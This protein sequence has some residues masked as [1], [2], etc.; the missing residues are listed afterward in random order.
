MCPVCGADEKE[1]LLTV[2]R[3]PVSCGT[4]FPSIEGAARAKECHLEFTVCTGC[5]H[6]WND[7][8]PLNQ[9]V[10]Y[11]ENYYSSFA[12]STQGRGYQKGLALD[13]DRW[14]Q[15]SGK[16]VLEIGCG[17][18]FFL[19]ELASLG[20]R[21]FGFEPSSTFEVAATQPGIKV[22]QEQF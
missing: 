17:D 15:V 10:E 21:A 7:S 1:P 20:A 5:G 9:A 14:V 4:L 13:L 16:T 3:A 6:I 11:E 18:G 2:E 8:H 12:A 22:F 19:K